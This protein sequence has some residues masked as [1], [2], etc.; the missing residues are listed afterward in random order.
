MNHSIIQL[1]YQLSYQQTKQSAT[2]LTSQQTNQPTNF[3][4]NQP[5]KSTKWS[6]HQVQWLKLQLKH[7]L[8]S[9]MNLHKQILSW[10]NIF[11]VIC[12]VA[13]HSWEHFRCCEAA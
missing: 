11:V 7:L 8:S 6:I 12:H 9:C 5:T 13:S 1:I 2:H 4:I 10:T 3:Q